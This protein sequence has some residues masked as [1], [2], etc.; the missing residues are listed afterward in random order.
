MSITDAPNY[1][2]PHP[3]D[4]DEVEALVA[5]LD[6]PALPRPARTEGAKPPHSLEAE[7]E[8]LSAVFIEP[9]AMVALAE[10]LHAEDFYFERHQLVFAVLFD[11]HERGTAIDIVTV[12]QAL[13]DR[14]QYEKIGGARAL[15]ELLDRA[16]TVTNVGHYI[17]IVRDKARLREVIDNAR[18][19]ETQAM[20]DVD[21][22]D[23]FVESAKARTTRVLDRVT[24]PAEPMRLLSI[25]ERVKRGEPDWLQQDPP[26]AS[27][28]MRNPDGSPFMLNSRTGVI[29]APGG[30]GKSWLV[31]QLAIAVA[32]GGRWLETYDCQKGR[33]LLALGEEK[34]EEIWRRVWR[35]AKHLKLTEY[36]R[37]EVARNLV[38]LGLDGED[39]AFLHKAP[40]GNITTT[41]WFARLQ[42]AVGGAAWKLILLD[43]LSYFGGPEVE[44]DPY[45]ATTLIR[46]GAK[47]TKAPGEPAVLF[48][49]HSRKRQQGAEMKLDASNTRGSSAIVDGSRWVCSMGKRSEDIIALRVTKTNYTV[50]GDELLL[51]RGKGGV[52][53]PATPEEIA[54]GLKARLD[55]DK[56]PKP[57]RVVYESNAQKAGGD[58]TL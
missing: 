6:V 26:D 2:A 46:C 51:T 27:V 8:V 11:L 4:L 19:I 12:H 22:V 53:R 44:N 58:N 1:D 54:D 38:P 33:V 55:A 41:P 10:S 45:V 57:K 9:N 24:K 52:L 5:S 49:A 23:A 34:D 35:V 37:E 25:A 14:G 42:Q 50:A 18:A 21:D 31:V 15:G 48:S 36:E 13:K 43:P 47:L 20:Q 3:A 28:L 17:G 56:A 16:G 30:T 39:V 29:E 32:C 40:D 7:R